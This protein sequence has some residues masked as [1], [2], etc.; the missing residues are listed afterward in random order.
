MKR[1]FTLIELLV[2]IAI[3]ALLSSVVLASVSSAR[4]KAEEAKILAVGKQ[5]E[6]AIALEYDKTGLFPLVNTPGCTGGPGG[7]SSSLA[8]AF[9][10]IIADGFIS[11][12]PSNYSYNYAYMPDNSDKTS[13]QYMTCGDQQVGKWY[14]YIFSSTKNFSSLKHVSHLNNSFDPVQIWQYCVAWDKP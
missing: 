8:Y 12:V 2:V 4:D 14:I 9:S 11:E 7:C 1:G 3:I 6:I 10:P 13:Q 5:L